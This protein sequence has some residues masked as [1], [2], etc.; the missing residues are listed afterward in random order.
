MA[1]WAA[2]GQATVPILTFSFLHACP[3]DAMTDGER[4]RRAAGLSASGA[5]HYASV[6][7]AYSSGILYEVDARLRPVRAAGM[8]VT[9]AE[10]FAVIRKSEAWTWEHQALVRAR[11]VRRSAAHRAL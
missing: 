3:M 9:S 7:Y 5:T 4:D 6:Q 11:S 8:L 2:G 10:A 1:S